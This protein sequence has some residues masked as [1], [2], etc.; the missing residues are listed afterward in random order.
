V[1]GKRYKIAY[2]SAQFSQEEYGTD[3]GIFHSGDA[4]WPSSPINMLERAIVQP[5]PSQISDDYWREWNL[6][7]KFGAVKLIC[8]ALTN[9]HEK[10]VNEST[11]SFCFSPADA[12]LRYANTSNRTNQL[13]FDN[14]VLVGG[15]VV[16]RDIRLLFLGTPSLTVHID[17]IE[18]M[19]ETDLPSRPA[20][21]SP[22]TRRVQVLEGES[23]G[24][25]IKK[26]MPEYPFSA[27]STGV[28]GVVVISAVISKDGHIQEAHV[29]AGPSQLQESAM[30]AVRQWVYRPFWVDGEAVEVE[31]QFNVVYSI[32]K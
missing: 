31:T 15:H 29:M 25:L 26:V 24:N 30:N 11:P 8:T 7:R 6:E 27:R 22:V 5:L 4:G 20:S 3:H 16:A 12:V 18:S 19:K 23:D 2:H 14:F 13:L 1:S 17:T 28:Q 10:K 9:N 32:G 21:E